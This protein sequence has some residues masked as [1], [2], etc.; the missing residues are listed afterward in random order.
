MN[1]DNWSD[2]TLIKQ[3]RQIADCCVAVVEMP[4]EQRRAAGKKGDA[5]PEQAG[6]LSAMFAFHM[7]R[8]CE[9]RGIEV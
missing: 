9:K 1:F 8:E 3:L 7:I 6:A 2:E 4:L 5:S